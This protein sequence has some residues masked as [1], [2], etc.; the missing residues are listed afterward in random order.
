MKTASFNLLK[1]M[2][3]ECIL[4][5]VCSILAVTS[6]FAVRSIPQSKIYENVKY[7]VEIFADEYGTLESGLHPELLPG[8]IGTQL[9]N[10][11]DSVMLNIMYTTSGDLTNDVFLCPRSTIKDCRPLATLYKIF[12]HNS[13]FKQNSY[14]RYWHGYQ[15]ILRPLLSFLSISS[16]RFLNMVFQLGCIVLLIYFLTLKK[17]AYMIPAFFATWVFLNPITL[18]YS[19]QYSNIFYITMLTCIIFVISDKHLH[20]SSAFFILELNAIAVAFFD[21]LTYPLVALGIPLIVLLSINT[22]N[23]I[24][25]SPT[26]VVKCIFSWCFGY[27]GMWGMKWIL[28]SVFT[29]ENIILN[30]YRAFQ[31]HLSASYNGQKYTWLETL[32]RNLKVYNHHIYILGLILLLAVSFSYNLIKNNRKSIC[33]PLTHYSAKNIV[34]S[35]LPICAIMLLPLLW[36]RITIR[37]SIV[38]YWMTHRELVIIIHALVTLSCLPIKH[39]NTQNSISSV[40]DDSNINH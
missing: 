24:K 27:V 36:Y 7:S 12:F 40:T 23:N 20:G 39:V 4:I 28:A 15:I 8:Y 26:Y 19:L 1:L 6:L 30:A 10:Y 38:H 9:D 32:Q 11:T 25:N 2:T 31:S 14:G 33:L 17:Y 21:L 22:C 18:I 5:A 29:T 34:L 3:K 35:R 16:I 37:H 13:S